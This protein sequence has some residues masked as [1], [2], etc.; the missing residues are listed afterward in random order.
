M[1]GCDK[2]EFASKRCK[3]TTKLKFLLA[4]YIWS[5]IEYYVHIVTAAVAAAPTEYVRLRYISRKVHELNMEMSYFVLV[6]DKW[7]VSDRFFFSHHFNLCAFLFLFSP[8]SQLLQCVCVF[9]DLLLL[10]F[11]CFR[12]VVV[13]ANLQSYAKTHTQNSNYYWMKWNGISNADRDTN[14]Q[15][16]LDLLSIYF[17]RSLSYRFLQFSDIE[18]IFRTIPNRI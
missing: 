5:V 9:C 10:C 6:L 17:F 11:W 13:V 16:L 12:F 15:Q 4:C 14:S 1:F 18:Q 7:C 3:H 8:S 2:L